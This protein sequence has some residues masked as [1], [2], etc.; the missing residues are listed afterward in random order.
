[1]KLQGIQVNPRG[2]TRGQHALQLPTFG[3]PLKKGS[4]NQ[5]DNGML[6]AMN[7]EDHYNT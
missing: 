3:R 5:G 7:N 1:M 2:V 4:A 6:L